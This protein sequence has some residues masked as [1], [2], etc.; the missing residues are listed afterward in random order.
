MK[1]A[2]YSIGFLLTGLSNMINVKEEAVHVEPDYVAGLCRR[3]H[4][5]IVFK[6]FPHRDALHTI[7]TSCYQNSCHKKSRKT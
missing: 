4:R 6:K 1:W 5:I 3:G 2:I 7:K